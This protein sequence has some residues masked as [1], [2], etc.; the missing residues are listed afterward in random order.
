MRRK[1]ID[2]LQAT[3]HELVIRDSESLQPAGKLILCSS[4]KY[5]DIIENHVYKKSEF[6]CS[7]AFLLYS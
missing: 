5:S 6:V 7:S 2:M 4:S 1:H 3:L